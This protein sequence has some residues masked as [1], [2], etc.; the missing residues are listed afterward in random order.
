[1]KTKK[2]TNLFKNLKKTKPLYRYMFLF[3]SIAY[4]ISNILLTYSLSLLDG[5]ENFIRI[6]IIFTVFLYFIIYFIA[7]LA[8]LISKKNK[9]LIFLIILTFIFAG[10]N[11]FSYY[12]I[13]K[14]YNVL[15]DI[16]KEK[17]IYTT[18]L[19][20]LK[21]NEN[22]IKN[23]GLLSN[24]KDI[25]GHILPQEY[26]ANNGLKYK[27]TYY[28]SDIELLNALY[29]SKEDAVFI[30]ANYAIKFNENEKFEHISDE[31]EV[32]AT[33][34][35]KMDNQDTVES[36][37]KDITEP[38]TVL[39]L[40]VDSKYDGL[41]N[42]AAFNGDSIMLITFNPKTLSATVFSIPRDTYVPIACNN[43]K[44]YKINSAAAYGTKC[45]IDTVQNL[46]D[47]PIDYYVKINFKGVV[48]LVEALDG[49][50]VDVEKPD[51]N[52]N[53]GHDCQKMV[54]EQNSSRDW[55]E[56][57]VYIP[58]GDSITLNG[59]QALAYSRNRHQWALS[60][61]K[62]IEHQ[63]TVVTAIAN[64]AKNIRDI[65]TLYKV[66]NAVANN[67]DT[68][69]ST[70]QI[71][72]F[73]NVAKNA[74]INNTSEDEFINI[75]KTYLT[76]YDLT[77]YINGS[78]T[79]T[80]Q[81]YEE[82][83]KEIVNAMKENLEIIKPELIKEFNFSVN[84]PYNQVVIGKNYYSVKRNE[85]LPNF[86]DRNVQYVESWVN[87]RNISLNVKYTESNSCVND[88]VLNQSVHNGTLVST[89]TS[90]SIDVCKN[91][92]V[93]DIKPEEQ[94]NTEDNK[95]EEETSSNNVIDSPIEEMVE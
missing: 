11:L 45:V 83:L 32:I 54:C 74:L 15:D 51:F 60:D 25:E 75:Q 77:L 6:A 56:D 14:T 24:E 65:N 5:I 1:M 23:V 85:T 91:I 41:A 63:Q 59:E 78:S 88:T 58:V 67:I 71:L 47:I 28:E 62:R 72:N 49:I 68:N 69:M 86:K 55:G 38:F 61:F 50:T 18:N 13:N 70:K 9:I 26:I 22:E 64:K 33:Y 73:Y 90:L 44:S 4:L 82:S 92:H 17:I 16:S 89:I 20:K 53:W 76:G 39:L 27:I 2:F 40:G 3:I 21:T 81:Y 94:N 10:V 87:E 46:V 57:T 80:Y 36:T 8:L 79:Y 48:S 52:K 93:E 34:S 84:E 66:L 35:K 30:T 42:N 12:Y 19:I 37:N 29:E 7:G 31:V 43:N 95:K